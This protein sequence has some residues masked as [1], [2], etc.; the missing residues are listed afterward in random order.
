MVLQQWLQT[1]Q[2]E[3]G[4]Q[5]E[6]REMSFEIGLT[7]NQEGQ[8]QRRTAWTKRRIFTHAA[9]GFKMLVSTMMTGRDAENLADDPFEMASWD[10]SKAHFHGEA[11]KWIYT[12]A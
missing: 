4:G 7:G 11:R 3:K 1:T 6:R 9:I 8:R 10:L 2:V 5:D 12:S